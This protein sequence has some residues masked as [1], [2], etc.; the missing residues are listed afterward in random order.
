LRRSNAELAAAGAGTASETNSVAAS[1]RT[2]N[3]NV[4]VA[5]ASGVAASSGATP[6]QSPGQT[7]RQSLDDTAAA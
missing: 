3:A 7:P 2:S 5:A 1:R 4:L 6:L